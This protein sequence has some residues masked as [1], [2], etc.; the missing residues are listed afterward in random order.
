VTEARHSSGGPGHGSIVIPYRGSGRLLAD[1]LAA[2]RHLGAD[3]LVVDLGQAE[4]IDSTVLELLLRTAKDLRANG[5]RLAVVC[6]RPSLRRLLGLT[7]LHRA[8]GVHP[9][10]DAAF[11]HAA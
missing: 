5:G 2:A 3:E 8:F 7:L 10:V 1:R 9:T 11:R 6:A 4:T